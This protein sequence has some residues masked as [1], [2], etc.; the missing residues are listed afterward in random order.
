VALTVGTPVIANPEGVGAVVDPEKPI[1]LVCEPVQLPDGSDVTLENAVLLDYLIDR[2]VV[3]GNYESWDEK[4]KAWVPASAAPEPQ[5]LFYNEGRWQALLIATG[6]KDAAGQA[7]FATDPQTHLPRYSARCFFRALD[8]NREQHDGASP[9]SQPVE[10]PRI[11]GREDQR[12]SIEFDPKPAANAT[13]VRLFLKDAG[14]NERGRVE[15]RTDGG[16][17]AIELQVD[18][19]RVLLD[20]AGG[21]TLEPAGGQLVRVNGVLAVRDRLDVAGAVLAP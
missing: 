5:K 21:I 10:I 8:A 15:I 2:E 14:L 1:Q 3:P 12:A 6:Q 7:K 4:A 20:G 13:S 11:P 17:F 19:S 16:G 9:R 18:S